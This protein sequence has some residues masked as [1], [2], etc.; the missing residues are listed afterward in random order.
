MH[1]VSMAEEEE[2]EFENREHMDMTAKKFMGRQD[3]VEFGDNEEILVKDDFGVY[4]MYD[5]VDTD[6][7][8][9]RNELLL[10]GSF[11]I[12]RQEPLMNSEDLENMSPLIDRISTLEM[13][14]KYESKFQYKKA[15]IVR[16]YME[17]Y[18]H[19]YDPLEQQRFIQMIVDF[20]AERPRL[21]LDSCSFEDSYKLELEI[22]DK[23]KELLENVI[24]FQIKSEKLINENICDYLEKGHK[25]LNDSIKGKWKYLRHEQING[26]LEKRGIERVVDED[27][28]QLKI[29]TKD[30]PEAIDENNNAE[31]SKKAPGSPTREKSPSKREMEDLYKQKRRGLIGLEEEPEDRFSDALGLPKIS[32]EDIYKRYKE[33]DQEALDM[34]NEYA[35]FVKNEDS[36]PKRFNNK[37]Y[38]LDTFMIGEKIGVLDFYESLGWIHWLQNMIDQWMRELIDVHK[39]INNYRLAALEIKLLDKAIS[40]FSDVKDQEDNNVFEYE[41]KP[42]IE[43]EWLI[44]NPDIIRFLVKEL[45]ASL[46][47][48][49]PRY[50]NPFIVG[51]L[52]LET[53]K[54]FKFPS[55]RG[56]KMKQRFNRK[57]NEED[58]QGDPYTDTKFLTTEEIANMIKEQAERDRKQ[59]E[60]EISADYFKIETQNSRRVNSPKGL[61]LYWNI[62]ELIRL[63]SV[64]IRLITET[65]E[66]ELIYHKQ[67]KRVG[68][69]SYKLR[70]SDQVR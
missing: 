54:F 13:L 19:I 5:C 69:E 47:S 37:E 3:F 46:N 8:M 45:T 42:Y 52:D 57:Y 38:V 66:L 28:S 22:L 30:I 40:K 34:M 20:M 39:P 23:R 4:I 55:S 18:E 21:N 62:L 65:K 26:E 9:L 68:R 59:T 53:I 50:I 2:Y 15:Q 60:K 49:D 24:R 64:L 61:F 33:N 43:D 56:M 25:I 14:M 48:G 70:F 67:R 16:L 1:R 35:T 36:N 29:S 58:G 63:R 27:K 6:L 11:Y 32:Q 31:G 44:G 51:K 10:A 12:K 17:T 7:E 41:G